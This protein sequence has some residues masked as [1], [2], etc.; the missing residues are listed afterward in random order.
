MRDKNSIVIKTGWIGRRIAYSKT[1]INR[2]QA[3]YYLRGL[4]MSRSMAKKYSLEIGRSS[5]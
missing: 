2:K 3:F 5:V 4:G 1:Y